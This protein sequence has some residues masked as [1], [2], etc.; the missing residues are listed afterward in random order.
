MTVTDTAHVGDLKT[1]TVEFKNK[2]G[3]LTNPTNVDVR[4]TDPDGLF[5]D[6]T[7]LSPAS[8]GKYEHNYSVAKAG[9][10]FVKWIGTGTVEEVT[11]YEF[12]ALR[13]Q[14]AGGSAAP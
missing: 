8:T 14:S 9:R 1:L 12:H 6:T 10:H 2:D 3:D 7:G 11:S 4:V 5:T 13:D